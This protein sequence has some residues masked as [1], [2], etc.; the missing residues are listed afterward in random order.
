M[1][2][3]FTQKFHAYI[4]YPVAAGLVVMPLVFGFTGLEFWLSVATGIAAF[5]LTV[6]TNHETGLIK[7][8]PYKLHLAVDGMVG[9]VFV[10]A[11]FALGFTG[12]AMA[13][14]L[15]LGLVVLMVVSLHRPDQTPVHPAE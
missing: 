8:L 2:G 14:Y 3:I 4:D 6:L 5:V 11:G 1:N 13:Y 10:I 7:I 12:L 15:V 9:V